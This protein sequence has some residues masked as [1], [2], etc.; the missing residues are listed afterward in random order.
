M[1]VSLYLV[2]KFIHVMAAITAVGA[3]ITYAIWIVRARSDTEHAGFALRGVKFIDD[4]IANPAYGVLLLTGLLMLVVGRTA[5]T[6]FWVIAALVLFAILVVIG[7]GFY[8][9]TLRDQIKLLGDGAGE[10]ASAAFMR[11]GRRGQI[12]GQAMGLV[13]VLIVVL[14]VFKPT[15]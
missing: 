6:T 8:S 1:T 2:L 15:L 10:A 3:N 12:L 14:M 11:L 13:V 9:P 4:R 7:I 5:L